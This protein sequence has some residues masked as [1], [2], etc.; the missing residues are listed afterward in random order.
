M[1][2]LLKTMLKLS[3]RM[4]LVGQNTSKG[5]ELDVRTFDYQT[6]LREY[7]RRFDSI[8]IALHIAKQHGWE[9]YIVQLL[10]HNQIARA[11]KVCM[12]IIRGEHQLLSSEAP[13]RSPSTK[14]HHVLQSLKGCI[15]LA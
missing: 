5:K 8:H 13:E 6:I 15:A 14:H 9:D 7:T 12:D 1:A 2:S 11:E 3:G 4:I 10:Q